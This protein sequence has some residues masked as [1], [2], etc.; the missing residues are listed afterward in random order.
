MSALHGI[1]RR[2]G[3]NYAPQV[4][5][6]VGLWA[7]FISSSPTFRGESAVY[8]VL[9]YFE[10][11]GLAAL[12][13][14]MTMI[15]GELD[16]SIGSMAALAGVLAVKVSGTGLVPSILIAVCFGALFGL[17]QGTIITRLSISS[18]A[19]TVGSLIML[20]GVALAVTHEVPVSVTNLS[21]GEPLLQRFWVFSTASAIAVV[22]FVLLGLFMAF[23]RIGHEMYATG[24]ARE[25]ARAAGVRTDRAIIVSFV[26]SGSLA[27]LAGTL[28]SLETGVGSPT[29]FTT[30][31][32][33]APTAVLVGGVAL[34]GGRGTVL[35]IA[36]G[37]AI[38]SVIATGL[39]NEGVEANIAQLVNGGLLV[40]VVGIE[41][42]GKHLRAARE[43]LAMRRG[44]RGGAAE[45]LLPPPGGLPGGPAK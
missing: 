38:I 19:V 28:S 24:G 37:V 43:R 26:L 29:N 41:F 9:Q 17:L 21:L 31:L 30:L 5:L 11:A 8:P 3:L 25:E 27:A 2:P 32:F 6:L 20:K 36:L 35:N 14:G 45:V 18:L 12:G 33:T 23:S 10:L 44:T 34:T 22:L 4:I 1:M 16:L 42:G 15:V 39:A 40:I 13:I 7:Y